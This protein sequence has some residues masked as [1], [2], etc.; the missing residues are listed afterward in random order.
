LRVGRAMPAP[1][2]LANAGGE[3]SSRLRDVPLGPAA[4]ACADLED[5]PH[6]RSLLGEV[7]AL[8][9]PGLQPEWRAGC[10]AETVEGT[11]EMKDLSVKRNRKKPRSERNRSDIFGA[12]ENP[13]EILVYKTVDAGWQK[14]FV[15]RGEPTVIP[16]DAVRLSIRFFT[17]EQRN[18]AL[19]YWKA[20][21]DDSWREKFLEVA[22]RRGP[23]S[24]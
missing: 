10:C 5:R 14:L 20:M 16:E 18:E 19:N 9:V 1:E 2:R 21:E 12:L 11:P 4:S 22:L 8:L 15:A 3:S 7:L 6:G 24:Q 13:K 17:P 23:D